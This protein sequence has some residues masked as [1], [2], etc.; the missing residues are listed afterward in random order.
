M[1]TAHHQS[2][3]VRARVTNP[4][5]NTTVIAEKAIS[6]AY[7]TLTPAA[8]GDEIAEE[9]IESAT[10]SSSGE[11]FI[12]TVPAPPSTVTVMTTNH[13]RM[14]G[15]TAGRDVVANRVFVN[16]DMITNVTGGAVVT[17]PGAVLATVH[18][19]AG[20]E[21]LTDSQGG[22]IEVTGDVDDVEARTGGGDIRVSSATR[23][24]ART[25]GGD[26]H[27][28]QVHT[29]TARSQGGDV[30]VGRAAGPVVMT[31]MGGDLTAFDLAAGGT[32]RTQGGNVR[33]TLTGN[34]RLTAST[35]GGDVQVNTGAG[36]DET[37]VNASTM[38]GDAR[39]N[40][41]NLS[42]GWW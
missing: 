22:D 26:I 39:I 3:L 14:V 32:L 4:A 9:L 6:T 28:D 15:V 40:G 16:G 36:V 21:I 31:S 8:T 35:M 33:V 34:A 27:L 24:Q 18:V 37:L 1:R 25:E 41:R 5:G 23:V 7:V 12:I 11:N 10:I 42:K 17:T 19:P 2:G 20:S 13:V 30:L 29:A 38:G